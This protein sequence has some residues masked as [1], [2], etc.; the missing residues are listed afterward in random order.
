M[1]F[2]LDVSV[3]IKTTLTILIV[4]LIFLFKLQLNNRS[5][6][7]FRM[8]FLKNASSE[9]KDYFKNL[10]IEDDN[11]RV[12]QTRITRWFQRL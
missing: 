10:K 12:Q 9:K 6:I 3:Y 8:I 11:R 1:L 5:A 7:A 4:Q 2:K